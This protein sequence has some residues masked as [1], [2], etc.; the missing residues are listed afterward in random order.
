MNMETQKLRDSK[1]HLALC[2]R[3]HSGGFRLDFA[4]LGSRLQARS[5]CICCLDASCRTLRLNILRLASR[6]CYLLKVADINLRRGNSA[7]GIAPGFL[8]HADI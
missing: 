8:S 6:P 1:A 3:V 4:P 7:G 5:L 2:E